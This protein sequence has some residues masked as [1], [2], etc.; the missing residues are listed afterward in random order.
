METLNQLLNINPIYITV[1][2]IVLFYTLE[3]TLYTPFAFQKRPQHLLNNVLIQLSYMFPNMLYAIFQVACIQWL[4]D[5][6]I[7]LFYWLSVPI[8]AQLV[9]GVALFDFTTYWLHRLTH[10]IPLLWRFHRVHH[11]DTTLDAS[12]SLRFHPIEGFFVFGIGYILT[13]V[14]F[15]TSVLSLGL[16]F[17]VF[18]IFSFLEHSNLHFPTWLDN[19]VG[20]VF[21]TPNHHKVHHEQNQFYTD[22][23]F[24]DIFILWDRLFGTYKYKSIRDIRYGLKEFEEEKKQSFWYQI[25]SPFVDI[26]RIKSDELKNTEMAGT[27][28]LILQPKLQE[29][30]SQQ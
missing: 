2:L 21:V 8:W 20:L 9:I 5:K 14:L 4:N 3:Q 28:R 23:N 22:S 12:T 18:N 7:G 17:L 11:S 25:I 24:A 19:T 13:T 30:I 10:K 26:R 27:E 15:G 29:D 6:H 1:G 16:Y